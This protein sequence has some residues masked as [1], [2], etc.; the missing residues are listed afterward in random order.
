MKILIVTFMILI[1][2]VGFA[3]TKLEACDHA[4]TQA[5][6]YIKEL[7]NEITI[8]RKLDRDLIEKTINLEQEVNQMKEENNK[9]YRRP[10][11]LILFG[12]LTGVY[13]L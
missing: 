3:K 12:M 10:S 1:S 7:N 11:V 6:V 5:E 9:W 4:L 8:R 2:N 13:V